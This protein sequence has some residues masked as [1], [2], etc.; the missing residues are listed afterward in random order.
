VNG[1]GERCGNA[2][3]SAIIPNL[4]LKGDFDCIPAA[5][6]SGLT[7]TA[8]RI[9][10]IANV[11]LPSGCPFV[12]SSAFAHKGGMHI[13]GVTKVS[14]SFEHVDPESVG[15]ERRFL[16]SEVSGRSTIINRIRRVDPSLTK[17]SPQTQ[18]IMARLKEL[19]HQGYQFEGAEASFDLLV[20]KLLGRYRP[21]FTLD[22]YRIICEQ[23]FSS[24]GL[25]ASAMI[26]IKV[27][28]QN[29]ITAA[30]GDG[31]VNAIDRALRKA[32][33]VFY[34]RLG[35]VHLTD[36][37]VRVLE[38]QSATAAKVRVLIETTDGE[39]IW[40]TVG[41]STDIIDASWI[42]LVDSIEY[43]FTKDAENGVG[44]NK[45]EK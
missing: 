16:M 38:P 29:E 31:P 12:G 24:E 21:F 27:S 4:Q 6:M 25:S 9:A 18:E 15:N 8:R 26:Q 36:Y 33:T 19:E 40:T 44:D 7:D 42:A 23:P 30:Q 35:D 20:R 45:K 3:L 14:R 41:V 22:Q 37:K 13:D 32:L 28:G 17:D 2:N 11:T 10:E 39:D 5:C 1:Y 34:P 43:K